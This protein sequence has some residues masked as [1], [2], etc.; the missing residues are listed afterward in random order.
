MAFHVREVWNDNFPQELSAMEACL[1]NYPIVSVDSEFPG[2]LR[3]TLRYD[4]EEVRFEKMKFNVGATYLIQLGLTLC[5]SN[6]TV[7]GVWQFN[8]HF[9]LD[10]DLHSKESIQ[11]L[12]GHG[13]D[14]Q[15]LKTHG[16]DRVKFGSMFRAVIGRRQRAIRW[17]SFHGVYDYAYIVKAVTFCPVAAS[18]EAFVDVLGRVFDSVVDVKY[19]AGLYKETGSEIG[20]QKLADALGVKRIGEAHTAASDSLLTALVYFELNKKLELLG[21]KE[22]LY[23]DFVYGTTTRILRKQ[24]EPPRLVYHHHPYQYHQHPYQVVYPVPYHYQQRVL[25]PNMIMGRWVGCSY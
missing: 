8:F 10:R 11:F 20:L 9:D 24:K 3:G 19:M 14:F 6:G 18:P 7:G 15:K 5:D 4:S 22:E 1:G 17:V 2:C 21:V 12:A 16:V 25:P 13:I 23:R